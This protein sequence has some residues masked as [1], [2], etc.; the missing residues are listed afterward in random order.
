MPRYLI[1]RDVP[2]IGQMSDRDLQAMA[3][4]SNRVM[5]QMKPNIHWQHSYVCNEKLYC[6]YIAP[7]EAAVREHAERGEF[8]IKQIFTVNSLMDATTGEEKL[9]TTVGRQIKKDI[10]AE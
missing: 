3:L 2:G 4:K 10:L 9:N 5:D 7:N 1:E 6:D 8:P